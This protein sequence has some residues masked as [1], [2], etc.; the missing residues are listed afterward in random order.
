MSGTVGVRLGSRTWAAGLA[1]TILWTVSASAIEAPRVVVT[2]KPIHSLVADVMKGVGRPTLLLPGNAS[3]HAYALRP[4]QAEDLRRADVVI[5]VG[6]GLESFL[7]GPLASLGKD[8]EVLTLADRPEVLLLTTRHGGIWAKDASEHEPA[9]H[10]HENA[11]TD[12][13]LWL[14]PVNAE[15]I[16][17]LAA[18]TLGAVDSANAGRYRANADRLAGTLRRLDVDIRAMLG[19]V[20]DRP[21]VVFH[22]AF[23]YFE[24][25]YGL[26]AVGS[27]SVSP[28]R[29]PG[30]RR[31]VTVRRR[32][33]D[34]KIRCVFAEPQFSTA[35]VSGV[36]RGSD[37]QTAVLDPL[38]AAAPT[39]PGAYE[40]ILRALAGAVSNCLR[41]Q[42]QIK[43]ARTN[44]HKL[45]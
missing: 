20:A 17:R 25:R 37:A 10:G 44:H 43:K 5:W 14:D 38:G 26:N 42:G 13:H 16:A 7:R 4:S 41:R 34:G 35:L 23:Q 33:R 32:I 12:P 22:D 36:T 45:L 30:A 28:E 40:T 31:M 39:G 6:P 24:N 11:E 15:A 3:P 18:Q 21:Y 1:L 19:P 9:D 27:L 2:I 29:K 8:T